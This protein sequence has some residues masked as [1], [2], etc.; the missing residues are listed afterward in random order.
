MEIG[1]SSPHAQVEVLASARRI[2]AT[3]AI[4]EK[5]RKVSE[6]RGFE[7]STMDR[8]LVA[9]HLRHARDRV[10]EGERHIREQQQ[11]IASLE[12]DGHE[13]ALARQLLE[14]LEETQVLHV[15][16]RDRLINELAQT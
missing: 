11:R 12:R 13:L 15:Q 3:R 4:I 16:D 2:V 1:D 14:T 8:A 9:E 6:A 5:S 10:A 7:R